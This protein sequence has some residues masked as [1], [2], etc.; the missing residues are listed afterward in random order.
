[1]E[2]TKIALLEKAMEVKT[3]ADGTE[4]TCF[5]DT[6]PE[7][8]KDLFLE[9]YNVR[10]LDYKIFSN[11]IDIYI[12]AWNNNEGSPTLLM[13]YIQDNYNDIGSVYTSDRLEYIDAWNQDEISEFVQNYKCDIPTG[14]AMWYDEQVQTAI[15]SI[16]GYVTKN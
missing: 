14:C 10:D 9:H 7:D 11:A 2:N 4:F 6:A 12:E 5:S 13:E 1:M 16:H 3:R 15:S 8:L